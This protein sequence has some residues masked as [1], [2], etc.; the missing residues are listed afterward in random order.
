MPSSKMLS[1]CQ[2][3]IKAYIFNFIKIHLYTGFSN[4]ESEKWKFTYVIGIIHYYLYLF[5]YFIICKF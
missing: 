2:H 1:L 3:I 5:K 4:Q